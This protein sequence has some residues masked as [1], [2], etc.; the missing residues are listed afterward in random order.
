VPDL[1]RRIV[2][3]LA[4]AWIAAPPAETAA[5]AQSAPLGLE[6][7]GAEGGVQATLGPVLQSRGIAASLESGLPVRIRVVTELWRDRFL[8]SQEARH[9][10]R[11]S[12]WYDPLDGAFLVQV[13]GGEP[14]A[15]PVRTASADEA[16]GLLAS[17]LDVPLRPDRPGRYYYLARVEVE[18]LSLSDLDELRRWLRGDLAPAVEGDARVGSAVGRGF[19]RLLVRVLGLPAERFQARSRTFEFPG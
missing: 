8:D 7:S 14:E 2:L 10:W 4:V 11:A 12:V 5:Q 17:L 3:L 19:Q 1:L 16:N 18:T 15:L 13:G 9:E 6:V